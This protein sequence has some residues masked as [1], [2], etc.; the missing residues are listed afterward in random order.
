[1]PYRIFLGGGLCTLSIGTSGIECF[2]AAGCRE[3]EPCVTELFFGGLAGFLSRI[4]ILMGLFFESLPLPR[5]D[6]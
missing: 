1:M 5:S 2:V 4:G 6:S 3:G